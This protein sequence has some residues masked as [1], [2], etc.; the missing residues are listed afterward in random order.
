MTGSTQERQGSELR[1]QFIAVLGHDL[2]NPLA[3]L[4]AGTRMLQRTVTDDKGKAVL[5]LMQSSISRMS[6]LIDNVAGFCPWP[7]RWRAFPSSRPTACRFRPVLEQVVAELALANPRRRIEA[8]LSEAMVRCDEGRIWPAAVEPS[9]Q[10]LDPWRP[11]GTDKG[12]LCRI[13][14]IFRID[15][16]QCRR[17]YPRGC[18]QGPVQAVRARPRP[19]P[20]CRGWALGS[21][22]PRKSPRRTR[23][24]FWSHRHRKRPVSPSRCRSN[25][26]DQVA[27]SLAPISVRI[28]FR[29]Q[30]QAIDRVPGTGRGLIRG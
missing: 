28:R 16:D 20:I 5:T 29:P 30:Y 14:R 6:G 23:V 27:R 24:S 2:R 15:G 8:D 25:N 26:H 22:S 19:G 7:A 18:R 12:T 4:D 21:I 17:A 1:E 9:G 11:G 13:R 3:S 10:C